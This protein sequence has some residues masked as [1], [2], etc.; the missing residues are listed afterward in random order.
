MSTSPRIAVCLAHGNEEMEVVNTI[1]ILRRA[2]FEVVTASCDNLGEKT[3]IGSRNIPLIADHTLAE[4]ADDA[5]DC[6]VL[7]G[8]LKGAECFRDSPLTMAFI[9]Q[10][11]YEG[12][13]VAAICASPAIVLLSPE[14]YPNAL[15][16]AHPSVSEL[17]PRENY[18]PKRVT[19]DANHNLMTSQGAGTSQE[20]ALEIVVH[21]GSKALAAEIA[22]SMVVWPNMNYQE[23]AER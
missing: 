5:F 18:R 3:L 23:R 1:D 4:I 8:G 10:H 14:L 19:F 13:L 21:L 16:T 20:F 17:I 11:K 7:P 6:V 2:N 22:E 15:M 12:K 9:E